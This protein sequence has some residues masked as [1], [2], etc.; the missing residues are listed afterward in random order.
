M[1]KLGIAFAAALAL[2]PIGAATAFAASEVSDASKIVDSLDV[3][4]VGKLI[5]EIG[6]QKV[7]TTE[8][9]DK[10]LIV[11]YE[12]DQPY[13]IAITACD[14]KPGKC[15]ALAQMALVDTS[16]ASISLDQLNTVNGDSLFMTGFKLDGNKI[17]FGRIIVVDGGVTRQNLAINLAVFVVAIPEALK[18]IQGQLTSSL[19]QQPN[20]QAAAALASLRFTPV[21]ADPRQL[22]A[23]SDQLLTPYRAMLTRGIRH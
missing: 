18:L 20:P 12:S 14:A 3:T 11:F 8:Q 22:R 1:Q 6:G 10:K 23:I 2:A 17:G 16:P 21:Q 7:E 9:G 5:A 4:A 13:I 15:I 19:Q